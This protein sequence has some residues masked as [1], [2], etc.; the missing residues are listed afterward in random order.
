MAGGDLTATA[1]G[2]QDNESAGALAALRG[3]ALDDEQATAGARLPLPPLSP[4]LREMQAIHTQPVIQLDTRTGGYGAVTWLTPGGTK[5]SAIYYDNLG[6]R[7]AL[8]QTVQWSW[9]TRYGEI[10]AAFEPVD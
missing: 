9:E 7:T 5:L 3:W 1:A 6:N 4:F 10:G 2:F 8:N